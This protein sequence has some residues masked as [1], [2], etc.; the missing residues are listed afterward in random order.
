MA[1]RRS[2]KIVP[3]EDPPD[4]ASALLERQ[5]FFFAAGAVLNQI[6][7]QDVF[8]RERV[9]SADRKTAKIGPFFQH[10]GVDFST[11]GSEGEGMGAG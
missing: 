4:A 10:S 6:P 3:V 1:V 7:V 11:Y 5:M 2:I 8:I 9:F